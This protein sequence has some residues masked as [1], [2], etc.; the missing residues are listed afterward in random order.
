MRTSFYGEN[1]VEMSWLCYQFGTERG[2][3]NEEVIKQMLKSLAHVDEIRIIVLLILH[4]VILIFPFTYVEFI[5]C[6]NIFFYCSNLNLRHK[7]I[8]GHYALR[9]DTKQDCNFTHYTCTLHAR[10]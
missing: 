9:D 6:G 8:H 4:E 7:Y 2:F 5:L 10:I 1:L 3:R